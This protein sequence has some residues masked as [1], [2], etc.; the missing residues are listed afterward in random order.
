MKLTDEEKAMLDGDRGVAVQKAMKFL[1]AYGEAFDAQRFVKIKSA[2][3]SSCG[4]VLGQEAGLEWVRELA[5]AGGHFQTETLMSPNS[6][7][8]DN[9]QKLG[10]DEELVKNQARVNAYYRQMGAR[11]NHSCI[12]QTSINVLSKGEHYCWGGSECVIPANSLWG[13]LGNREGVPT[14]I[15]AA[16]AGRVPEQGL[17]LPENRYGEVLVD[18]KEWDFDTITYPELVAIGYRIGEVLHD[19]IPVITDIKPM[20]LGFDQLRY[21][22]VGMP[23]G[24]AISM[25]HIVGVT[26]EANTLEEAFGGKEPKEKMAVTRADIDDLFGRLTTAKTDKLDMVVFGCPFLGYAQVEEIASY[27]EGRKVHP[28]VKLWLGTDYHVKGAAERAGYAETIEK[29]GGIISTHTCV[30][31]VGP[32]NYIEGLNTLATDNVR[33]AYYIRS[34]TAGRIGIWIGDTKRCID[35]AIKGRWE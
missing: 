1:V 26:P 29:A 17:H 20:Q 33:N 14:I 35:A 3:L 25:C 18:L 4:Y 24:G 32:F 2:R 27:L 22:V 7:D 13:A 30:A 5:E 8:F 12:P 16:L 11:P 19:K 15:M 23:L 10:I 34:I 21:F 6:V 28:D 9:W 31:P